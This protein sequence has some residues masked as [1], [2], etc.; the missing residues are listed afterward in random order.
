M[1]D[2]CKNNNFFDIIRA[3]QW[4]MANEKLADFLGTLM[5]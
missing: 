2:Y 4:F 3:A 1:I 5:R